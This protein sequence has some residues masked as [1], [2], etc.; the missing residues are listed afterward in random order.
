MDAIW[1]GKPTDVP[2]RNPYS[3]G[4]YIAMDGPWVI[5]VGADSKLSIVGEISTPDTNFVYSFEQANSDVIYS[6]KLVLVDAWLSWMPSTYCDTP[7]YPSDSPCSWGAADSFLT[8]TQGS[9]YTEVAIHVRLG[10]YNKYAS[11]DLNTGPV[12][13]IFL[14]QLV[15]DTVQVLARM[16]VAVP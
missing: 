4:D 1:E 15:Q 9:P 12:H 8:A 6:G 14:V 10:D 7:P 3:Q 13:G 11:A 5:R 2:C 16:E